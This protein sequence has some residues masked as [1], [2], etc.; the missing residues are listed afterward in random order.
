M[1]I[2]V[3][4]AE[5]EIQLNREIQ[6]LLNIRKRG[7]EYI[8][9]D[10]SNLGNSLRELMQA[11]FRAFDMNNRVLV[12]LI[13]SGYIQSILNQ[14]VKSDYPKFLIT[15]LK[16]TDEAFLKNAVCRMII[17]YFGKKKDK[18]PGSSG[19]PASGQDGGDDGGKI[20]FIN[21]VEPLIN[22]INR[23]RENGTKL[24]ALSL[25]AIINMSNFSEDIKDIFLQKNGQ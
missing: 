21:M 23:S 20:E 22:I 6:Y 2:N 14:T 11:D 25:M 12:V 3:Q 19:G 10:K 7:R 16:S 4:D 24:T 18:E 15:V 8:R 1:I 17:K 9:D 13:E 5:Q